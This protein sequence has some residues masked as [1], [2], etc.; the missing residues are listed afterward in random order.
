MVGLWA[1]VIWVISRSDYRLDIGFVLGLVLFW[2]RGSGDVGFLL[3]VWII[4]CGL[5]FGVVSGWAQ[6][7]SVGVV[8]GWLVGLCLWVLLGCGLGLCQVLGFLLRWVGCG[9]CNQVVDSAPPRP[10]RRYPNV[11][12]SP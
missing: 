9:F 1:C 5:C 2:D 10:A 4:K 7:R 3:G 6:A 11:F 8:S 12:G